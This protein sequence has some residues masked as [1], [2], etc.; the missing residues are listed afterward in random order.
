MENFI[1]KSILLLMLLFTVSL[2]G[3][4]R[5]YDGGYLELSGNT[6]YEY[7]NGKSEVHNWFKQINET[8]DVWICD[9][10]NCQLKIP[11]FAGES[12][13]YI[14]LKNSKTWEKKYWVDW[15]RTSAYNK[16]SRS[17][18]NGKSTASAATKNTVDRKNS[19][20]NSK[21]VCGM[22]GGTGKTKCT[23]CNGSGSWGYGMQCSTCRGTGQTACLACAMYNAGMK[24]VNEGKVTTVPAGGGNYVNPQKQQHNNN[25]EIIC[26][27]CGGTGVCKYCNG[28][29]GYYKDVGYYTGKTAVRW[30]DCG[31]CSGKGRCSMCR[32]TGKIR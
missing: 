30:I 29:K 22:C 8:R 1:K 16:S 14:K 26:S 6:W 19:V 3:Q 9:N 10:G 18:S 13:V 25:R 27:S 2:Y 24:A 5:Y 28:T 21:I 12:Y 31:G 20:D 11:K 7:K 32:G 17:V 23:M 4:R 15:N